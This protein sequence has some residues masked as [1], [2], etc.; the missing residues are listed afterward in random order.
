MT[1]HLMKVRVVEKS[2]K[3]KWSSSEAKA[4]A[5]ELEQSWKKLNE[6]HSAPL[7][8]SGNKTLAQ[9]REVNKGFG[10]LMAGWSPPR[11]RGP[12]I[13]SKAD[14]GGIGA[15]R[16]S[17]AYTGSSMKGISTLHK[18]NAVPVFSQEE[19]IDIARMRRG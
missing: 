4:K 3:R 19:A 8:L 7:G 15:K 1:M 17:V 12:T 10:Y 2:N 18:S 11:G 14:T 5:A 13:P 16:E 9:K 6:K